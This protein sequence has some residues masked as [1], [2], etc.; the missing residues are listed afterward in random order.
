M[1]EEIEEQIDEL[2][3]CFVEAEF[4]SHWALIAGYHHAGALIK[5][6]NMPAQDLAEKVGRSERTINYAI[7]LYERYPRLDK[8][9]EGKNITMN[10]L[11]T[12]YLTTP[13]GKEHIH[14][15]ITVCSSCK[16]RKI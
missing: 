16:E 7:K 12:K 5:S 4:A 10:K 8:I 14:K 11:I 1:L 15:W 13:K 2:R 6:I 3:A 9:P